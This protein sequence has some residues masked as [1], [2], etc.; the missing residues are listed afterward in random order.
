LDKLI[1]KKKDYE[2]DM[3]VFSYDSY[4]KFLQEKINLSGVYGYQAKLATRA[5][6]Q[7]PYIS[8]VLET[9]PQG[10]P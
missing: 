9:P 5:Q 8:K 2:V 10:C 3:N 4:Q 6:C 1:P 7:S